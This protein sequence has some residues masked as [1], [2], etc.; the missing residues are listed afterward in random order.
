MKIKSNSLLKTTLLYSVGNLASKGLS[1]ILVFFTTFYLSTE[2]VGIFDLFLTTVSLLTPIVTLQLT[3]AVLRW[4][5]EN[6]EFENK[7][8]VLSTASFILF[9]AIFISI[10]LLLIF[11][12]YYPFLYYKELL[13][14][15]GFQSFFL[16][17]QQYQ[18]AIGDNKGYVL[19]SVFYTFLYVILA[20]ICLVFYDKKI[21]GLLWSNIV[22]AVF[23][24]V[25]IVFRNKV[26]GYIHSKYYS[27]QVAKELLYYSI[28]LVPNSLSWWAISSAN[29]YLIVL[30]LGVASNG[31]FAIAFKF[32]TIV[33]LIVSVFYLAWQEKAIENYN[34]EDKDDY[35]SEIFKKY[36]KYLFVISINLLCINQFFLTYFVDA[37]FYDSWRYTSVLLLAILFNALS[38][39]YGAIY[40]GAKKTRSI[41]L[42]S[43][44]SGI[45]V[46]FLSYFLIP[47]LELLGAAIAIFF[48]YFFLF[49]YRFFET[50]KY[51]KITFPFFLFFVLFSIFMILSVIMYLELP[52][53][54]FWLPLVSLVISCFI[55]KTDLKIFCNKY[56]R[57]KN[58][59]SI[60]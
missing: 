43:L 7:A 28:P 23:T 60:G 40:L 34:R 31:I 15:L 57:N 27:F 9:F 19:S 8:R 5:I 25:F 4:L 53:G 20:I 18:R 13:F 10:V 6:K 51:I 11:Q 3:D 54:I 1:F 22:A 49:L 44:I 52:Y 14:L 47:V 42:S 39:F 35:Y 45:I 59:T 36:L 24:T 2:D 30:F 58:K 17:F 33:L 50:K 12:T 16:L 26:F 56:W 37:M 29:R 48:G 21:E 38:G 46:L 32:P 41:F 55:M